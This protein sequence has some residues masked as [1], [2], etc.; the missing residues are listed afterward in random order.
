MVHKASLFVHLVPGLV[1]VAAVLVH[2]VVGWVDRVGRAD[3]PVHLV[4]GWVG[5][6]ACFG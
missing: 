5:K 4:V 2:L 3:V 6:A 1:G